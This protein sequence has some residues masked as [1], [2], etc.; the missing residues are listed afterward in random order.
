[1]KHFKKSL[2]RVAKAAHIKIDE[3]EIE[4]FLDY[5]QELSRW[6][7]HI[8]LISKTDLPDF[9]QKHLY[10]V[11]ILSRYLK[12][13]NL[14]LD[15]GAGGGIVGIP[16]AIILKGAKVYLL[17]SRIKKSVFLKHIVAILSLNA[18]VFEGEGSKFVDFSHKFDY[19]LVKGLKIKKEMFSFLKQNGDL[20]HIGR[21]NI[22]KGVVCQDK[23]IG[24][25]KFLWCK[26]L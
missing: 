1:V 23:P 20:I 16:L 7:E 15:Y 2:K 10:P 5:Y 24:G 26:S 11:F 12:G 9:L 4:R 14:I 22:I 18:V 8:N 17:E 21:T 6:N 19:V 3:D 25:V 13:D